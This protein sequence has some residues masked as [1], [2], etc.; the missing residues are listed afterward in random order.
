MKQTIKYLTGLVIIFSVS[1]VLVS[2]APKQPETDTGVKNKTEEKQD[3]KD[4]NATMEKEKTEQEKQDEKVEEYELEQKRKQEKRKEEKEKQAKMDAVE[5]IKQR[6]Y[7]AFDSHQLSSEAKAKLKKKA[8]L[9]QKYSDM[10]LNIGGHCDERGTEEYN[11][12]LGERR[13]KAAYEFLIVLGVD[14]SRMSYVSYGE[15]DPLVEG[16]NE[17]A[18]AKNRRAEFQV[19]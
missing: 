9:L 12:A 6:I 7:F 17:E 1:L 10:E 3:K 5:T 19:E 8:K 11:L 2:C 18:W 16:H 4:T 13:A 15:E 14:S